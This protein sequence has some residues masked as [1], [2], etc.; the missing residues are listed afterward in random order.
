ME[1]YTKLLLQE[2]KHIFKSTSDK[3][4]KDFVNTSD[5]QDYWQH[6]KEDIQSSESG[7]HFGHYKAASFDK[8]LSALEAAKLM[9]AAKTEVPL[10][11]W[12]RGLTILLE[13]IL[14]T[15]SSIKCVQSVFLRPITTG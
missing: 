5:F 10:Q 7:I 14:V 6:A 13:N 1:R 15:S 11:H 8:Y 9:L 3:D 12:R 4:V 2:S